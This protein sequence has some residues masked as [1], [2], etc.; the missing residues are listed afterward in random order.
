MVR[1]HIYKAGELLPNWIGGIGDNTPG[2][3][4]RLHVAVEVIGVFGLMAFGVDGGQHH[5]ALVINR[6]R[7]H[8]MLTICPSDLEMRLAVAAKSASFSTLRA[9][10][11][12][13]ER[14]TV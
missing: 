4:G 8:S 11:L 5:P 13:A 1:S 14:S 2:V 12:T 3:G 6:S 9:A 10:Q 7:G